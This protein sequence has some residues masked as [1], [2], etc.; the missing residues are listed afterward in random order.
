HLPWLPEPMLDS[1]GTAAVK[2]RVGGQF[3]EIA[4]T[5]SYEDKPREGVII[6]GGD[7]KTDS[8]NAFWTDSW[9]MAHQ[10]MLCE[11]TLRDDG[12]ISVKGYYK[13]PDHPD[14][15]WRTEIIPGYDSF[16][17]LMYNVTPDG[18]ETIAVEMDLSRA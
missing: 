12:S 5:W 15:G 1:D 10:L 13:V 16:R 8:V 6:L 17:Y 14:W 2:Q 18:E 7:N 9:H 11:G 4:Y 3:L